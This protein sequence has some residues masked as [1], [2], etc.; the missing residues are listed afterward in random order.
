MRQKRESRRPVGEK[1]P[2]PGK[3]RVFLSIALELFRKAFLLP[4]PADNL[5][6]E[7]LSAAVRQI[8]CHSLES[9]FGSWKVPNSECLSDTIGCFSVLIETWGEDFPSSSGLLG[10]ACFP[11]AYWRK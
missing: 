7:G 5:E 1:N 8:R 6:I 2:S 9:D 11:V 3:R 4:Y 10:I